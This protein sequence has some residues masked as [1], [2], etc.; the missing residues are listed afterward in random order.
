MLQFKTSEMVS[1][2]KLK[3]KYLWCI[4]EIKSKRFPEVFYKIGKNYN[5]V[6]EKGEFLHKTNFRQNRF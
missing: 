2:G 1:G 3:I 4:I 5:K 6:T